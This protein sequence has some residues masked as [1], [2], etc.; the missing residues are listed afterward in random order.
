MKKE[1]EPHKEFPF[2]ISIFDMRRSVSRASGAAAV[3]MRKH[4]TFQK[5]AKLLLIFSQKN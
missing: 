3:Q 5:V 1:L 4:A 2:W